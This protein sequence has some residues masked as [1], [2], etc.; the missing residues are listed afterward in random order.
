[1]TTLACYGAEFEPLADLAGDFDVLSSTEL[2]A[3]ARRQWEELAEAIGW[4]AALE[5]GLARVRTA[6]LSRARVLSVAM[7]AFRGVAAANAEEGAMAERARVRA[8]VLRELGKWASNLWCVEV[9]A[10][11]R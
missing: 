1:M 11:E 4:S 6:K 2:G 8:A 5:A 3:W 9:D 7:A 10:A